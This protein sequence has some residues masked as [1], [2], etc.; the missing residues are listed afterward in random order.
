MTL[1]HAACALPLSPRQ[2]EPNAP[3]LHAKNLARRVERVLSIMW[4]RP[5]QTHTTQ[6]LAGVAALSPFHFIRVFRRV[7][8]VSPAQ[9]LCAVR[10]ETAKH[11]LLTTRSSVT[12]VCF[13]VGYNSLG[14]FV[15]RF[16]QLV[17]LSPSSFR[18][19]AASYD[20]GLLRQMIE[21]LE[22]RPAARDDV[23]TVRGWVEAP[24]DFDGMIFVGL[25]QTRMAHARPLQCDV[26]VGSGQFQL[27]PP[28]PG[29][30]YI[31]AA[32]IPWLDRSLGLTSQRSLRVISGPI[33]G[34]RGQTADPVRL[35]LR[36]PAAQDPPIVAALR[37]LP[38]TSA[39][40]HERSPAR[41]PAG[42]LAELL[43]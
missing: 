26:L 9:Y 39:H 20:P 2:L 35:V 10:L 23:E 18:R 25:F 43:Q 7:T 22:R 27:R 24:A 32:G 28:T 17:G 11:L 21:C 4:S 5:G 15:T 30:F 40:P 8:G 36:P 37:L 38:F 3:S 1:A 31:A 33:D 6:S 13:D 16:T 19:A 12:D 29:P 42:E 41:A 34:V 14:T